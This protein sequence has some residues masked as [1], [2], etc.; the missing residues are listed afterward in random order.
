MEWLRKKQDKVEAERLRQV[1]EYERELTFRPKLIR[2]ITF[3]NDKS[4]KELQ[5]P[6]SNKSLPRS[7]SNRKVTDSG[8]AALLL[9]EKALPK[10]PRLSHHRRQRKKTLLQ[11]ATISQPVG[12]EC[13][14]LDKMK[15]E[16]EASMASSRTNNSTEHGNDESQQQ[17]SDSAHTDEDDGA[18]IENNES[19]VEGSEQYRAEPKTADEETLSPE[20][21]NAP[22][23]S[24]RPIIGGRRTDLSETKVRLPLQ[25]ASKFELST[26]YRKTDRR[27]GREGVALH[28]GRREDTLEE[29]VIAV[30]FDK[31]KVTEE[32]AERW[33]TQHQHRFDIE[34]QESSEDKSLPPLVPMPRGIV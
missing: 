2:R 12:V 14:L 29:Q 31:E 19:A 32:D 27:A 25:D 33:W 15:S 13:K 23:W 4:Y 1:E 17:E 8:G 24:A 18:S 9:K 21:E 34:P 11:S 16:L 26:M 10:V 5:G 30:L 7:E 6:S 28:V 3:S 22:A 20:K